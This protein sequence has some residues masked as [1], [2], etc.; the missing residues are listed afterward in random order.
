MKGQQIDG[1]KLVRQIGAGGF[2]EV[3]LCESMA[4]PGIWKAFKWIP[5]SHSDRLKRE[6]AALVKF[7]RSLQKRS[8]ANLM[9]I[10][11]VNRTADGLFYVMPLADGLVD[12]P[13]YDPSWQPASL[14]N[15]IQRKK[16]SDQWFSSK[17]IV[18]MMVGVLS[19]LQYL[20]DLGLVHRDLKPENILFLDGTPVIADISLVGQDSEQQTH[21][22]TPG[23]IA[24]SW[25]L[26]GGGHPDQYAAG[27]TLFVLMTGNSPDKMGRSSFR[28]PPRGEESLTREERVE[29]LKLHQ[30]VY[31]ATHETP[32]ERF[33][34]FAAIRSL[35]TASELKP[36]KSHSY[37]LLAVTLAGLASAGLVAIKDHHG[38]NREE[39]SLSSVEISP[40]EE[41]FQKGL[42][43]CADKGEPVDLGLAA[44][45]FAAGAK[46][47][48]AK[49]QNMVGFLHIAR[50]DAFNP[51]R[52]F[53]WFQKAADQGDAVGQFNLGCCYSWGVGVTRDDT[54]AT[55][56]FR[57]SAQQGFPAAQAALGF[58]LYSAA[59][60]TSDLSE[61]IKLLKQAADAG[62]VEA[63]QVLAITLATGDGAPQD[64]TEARKWREKVKISKYDPASSHMAVWTDQEGTTSWRGANYVLAGRLNGNTQSQQLFEFDDVKVTRTESSSG[65]SFHIISENPKLTQQRII[66]AIE[67]NK[68]GARARNSEAELWIGKAYLAG[69]FLPESKKDALPWLR[70]AAEQGSQEALELIMDVVKRP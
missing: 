10:E 43:A 38:D 13:P 5:A 48:H 9:R 27:V 65:P 56:W 25:Y 61:A 4:M 58:A 68:E 39:D 33:R 70:R 11:H 34:D 50:N 24:P 22:G 54:T 44:R 7:Q 45:L 59:P 40:V 36:R 69:R 28:W 16:H 46:Q 47:G 3:W 62:R 23:F 42:S 29:W 30:I 26:E 1:Y 55:Q 2:G 19:G 49:S 41:S 8:S 63:M 18:A 31:R 12:V 52:A 20:S 35:L 14:S 6:L 64:E 15:L 37:T 21:R 66:D 32:S 17:E 67:A 53:P 60:P 51:E 57:R